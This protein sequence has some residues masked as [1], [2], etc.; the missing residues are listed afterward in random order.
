[1]KHI[2][3]EGWKL[4]RSAKDNQKKKMKAEK[5]VEGKI[6][7]KEYRDITKFR[8]KIYQKCFEM[9]EHKEN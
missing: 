6:R 1:M 8:R 3:F 4:A 5:N 7:E 9:D 2:D